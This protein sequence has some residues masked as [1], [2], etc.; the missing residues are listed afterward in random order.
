MRIEIELPRGRKSDGRKSD[1][2]LFTH[3]SFYRNRALSP[4]PENPGTTAPSNDAV[5]L[6][7]LKALEGLPPF[8]AVASRILTEC[9]K[10]APEVDTIITLIECDAALGGRVLQLV[11]SPLYAA[12]RQVTSIGHAVVMLGFKCV[13]QMAAAISA[14][15]VFAGGSPDYERYRRQTFEQS[16]ACA[17]IAKGLSRYVD[18]VS[19]DE[20]FLAG[21]MHDVGKLVMLKVV[22]EAY[23]VLLE[24]HKDGMTSICEVDQ[25]GIDHSEVGNRCGAKW[26]LPAE[27]NTAI[28]NHHRDFEQTDDGLSKVVIAA[29]YLARQQGIGAGPELATDTNKA[30]EEAIPEV[31]DSSLHE[32]FRE[33]YSAINEICSV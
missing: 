31:Q 12:S 22:P 27:I 26:G 25:F 10:P 13:A 30:I 20:A 1:G 21:V 23:C 17:T 9:Q 3:R 29:N 32:T 19:A 15:Q 4:H 33:Q 18:D 11:N 5:I 7:R 8:P 16:L 2:R 6:N 14:G 28:N 24:E